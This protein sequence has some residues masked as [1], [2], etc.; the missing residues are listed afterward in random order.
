MTVTEARPEPA[1]AP[2]P[3]PAVTT[4]PE[5][6][7]TTGDHK[8]L[9]LLFLYGSLVFLVLGA[10]LGIILRGELTEPG[11]QILSGQAQFDRLF[12]MHATVM[13]LLFLAPAWTGLATYVV[14][15]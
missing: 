8:K 6:W 3:A 10:A 11:V 7:F 12:S 4:T 2:A 15:L 13:M 1:V 14:P 9:G 5:S